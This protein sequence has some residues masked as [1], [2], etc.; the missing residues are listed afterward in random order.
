[1][2]LNVVCLS[3]LCWNIASKTNWFKLWLFWS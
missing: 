2:N 1:M 3:I